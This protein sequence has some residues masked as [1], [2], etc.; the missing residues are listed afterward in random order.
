M[1]M[2]TSSTDSVTLGGNSIEEVEAFTYLGS[3][4]DKQGGTDADVRSRIGKARTAFTLLRNIWKSP[5][6]QTKIKIR[7]FNSNVK[8][9]LVYGSETWRTTM[10]VTKKVQT[11]IKVMKKLRYKDS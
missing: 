4:I 1:K 9:V 5:K 6:L 7:F 11:L 3:I 8:A 2:N 10:T